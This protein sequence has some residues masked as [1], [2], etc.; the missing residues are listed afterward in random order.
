MYRRKFVDYDPTHPEIYDNVGIDYLRAY[1]Q[2]GTNEPDRNPDQISIDHHHQYMRVDGARH[3]VRHHKYPIGHNPYLNKPNFPLN[4]DP[5]D[6][7]LKLPSYKEYTRYAGY[8]GDP[9]HPDNVDYFSVPHDS[10]RWLDDVYLAEQETGA[11]DR[12][13]RKPLAV[14][15][16]HTLVYWNNPSDPLDPLNKKWINYS[17]PQG[18][19]HHYQFAKAERED[20]PLETNLQEFEKISHHQYV[21]VNLDGVVPIYPSEE[22]TNQEGYSA[23]SFQNAK[24]VDF[25]TLWINEWNKIYNNGA[26]GTNVHDLRY[27]GDRGIRHSPTLQK[28]LRKVRETM[29]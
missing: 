13:G 8:E 16:L 7:Q 19:Q 12:F 26:G 2:G 21:R 29:V 3:E 11:E 24:V 18:V 10:L 25:S 17:P 28:E 14:S 27:E 23:E 22:F 6:D 20:H 15:H 1:V 4:A 5:F 9:T